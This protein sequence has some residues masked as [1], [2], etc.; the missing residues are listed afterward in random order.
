VT[1][2]ITPESLDAPTHL[3]L[4]HRLNAVDGAYLHRLGVECHVERKRAGTERGTVHGGSLLDGVRDAALHVRQ[5]YR[6][7]ALRA[8]ETDRPADGT[9][10]R[11]DSLLGQPP[12]VAE[13]P[14]RCTE[15]S[16]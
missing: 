8:C 12:R 5:Q 1:V 2:Y 3:R 4:D 6:R 13:S 10:H 15:V 7:G 11:G 16:P 9:A 14:K